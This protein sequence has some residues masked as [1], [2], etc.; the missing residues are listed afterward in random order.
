MQTI[1]RVLCP[2]LPCSALSANAP[3]T[4]PINTATTTASTSNNALQSK[5][6]KIK[7]KHHKRIDEANLLGQLTGNQNLELLLSWPIPAVTNSPCPHPTP[8]PP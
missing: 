1:R 5:C 4:T 2:L 3:D 7:A 8:A 6:E